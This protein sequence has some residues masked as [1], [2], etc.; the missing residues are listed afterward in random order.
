[1]P[2]LICHR[3]LLLLLL[4]VA[5]SHGDSSDD[6]AYDTSMCLNQAYTCGDVSISYPFYL[7][8]ETKDV[9]G[10]ANSYCGYPGLGILCDDD[11]PILQLNG[12]ENY[13]VKNIDGT[14]ATVSL[15]D[16][17]VVGSSCPKVDHNVTIPPVSWL[18]FPNST[19]DYIFFYLGCYFPDNSG[20]VKPPAIGNIT[21][22]GFDSGYFGRFSFVIPDDKVPLGNWSQACEQIYKV[23]VLKHDPVDPK[24]AGWVNDGYGKVLSR[25][26]QLFWDVKKKSPPCMQCEQSNSTGRCAYNQAGGF[27]GCLCSN[28]RVSD[29]ECGNSTGNATAGAGTHAQPFYFSNIERR[30]VVIFVSFTSYVGFFL[31]RLF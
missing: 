19:V 18:D 24:D 28:G 17:E 23:P 7:A 25:G 14:S 16:P 2:L 4:L 27:I 22:Q 11:K 3:L 10:Y 5:A 12:T 30:E 1:M 21:C 15:A 6:G 26:F 8:G 9:K 29:K 13:T 31:L 20:F